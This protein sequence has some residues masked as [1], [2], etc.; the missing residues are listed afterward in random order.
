MKYLNE[1]P[2]KYECSDMPN[3][4]PIISLSDDTKNNK[5]KK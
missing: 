2:R 5:F 3:K 1:N 4:V